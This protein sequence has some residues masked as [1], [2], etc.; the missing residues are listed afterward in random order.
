MGA[1]LSEADRRFVDDLLR[2]DAS[3]RQLDS[4]LSQIVLVMAGVLIVG[5][6]AFTIVRLNDATVFGVLV[7]GLLT[8]LFLLGLYVLNDRRVRE[9]RRLAE[10]VRKMQDR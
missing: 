1:I 10:I 8:G 3:R 5:A 7:P 4:L 9:R 2:W 6:I